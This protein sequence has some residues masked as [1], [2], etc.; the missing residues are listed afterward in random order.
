MTTKFWS[1]TR[2]TLRDFTVKSFHGTVR[3]TDE[4]S[5]SYGLKTGLIKIPRV[6]A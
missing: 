6:E 3:A 1:P 5:Q 2:T 4:A